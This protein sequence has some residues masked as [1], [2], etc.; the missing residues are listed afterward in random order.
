MNDSD[1][2]IELDREWLDAFAA[3]ALLPPDL[4]AWRPLV[5]EGL[6]AFLNGLPQSRIAEILTVQFGLD[7]DAGAEERLVALLA[8][9]PTLHKLGQ[10][11]ARQ[12]HLDES[13]RQRLKTLES[14]P[15]TE[16][17]ADL[18]ALVRARFGAEAKALRLDDAAL[19]QG[20]VAVVLPFCWRDGA[21]LREGVF[22]VLRPGVA[23][24][25]AEELALLPGIA[26]LLSRRGRALGLP[27]FDYHDLFVGLAVLLGREIRLPEEQHNLREAAA[28]HADD[29]RIVIP[30][31][32]PWCAPDVTAMSRVHGQPLG[33]TL[34]SL[35]DRAALATTAMTALIAR[36][37]FTRE[38]PVSFHGDLHGG[39][40]L[41]TDD[42]RL[43]V[44]DWALTARVP[45]PAR[46]AVMA[47]VVAGLTLDAAAL[48]TALATLGVAAD[49]AS[50]LHARTERALDE[51]VSSGQPASFDWLLGLLDDCALEGR[52]RFDGELSV[53]RK[54]WLTLSGVLGDLVGTATP[55]ATLVRAGVEHFIA[56]MPRR[57]LPA[58]ASAYA[59]HL[60]NA[61]IAGAM[62]SGWNTGA[63]YWARRW[64][65]WAAPQAG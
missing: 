2:R 34:L 22:K 44:L 64:R 63:R 47:A 11:L 54:S 36:P 1:A 37:F 25:L 10:V 56:E 33:S 53:F 45:K 32:L 28:F 27:P 58:P 40:L 50:W 7:A 9:C 38:D 6:L 60:S 65:L 49:D 29:P 30:A 18:A 31:V 12:R 4:A 59:T 24:R 55:D 20:S 15:P 39:N 57:W 19:A 43:A 35:S 26:A 17:V 23:L 13:L 46:E 14:M 5:V 21:S 41:V 48:R 42:G 3:D 62:V 16:S 8:C 61:D 51:R 52:A